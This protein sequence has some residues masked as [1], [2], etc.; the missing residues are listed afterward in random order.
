M[1]ATRLLT[2]ADADALADL[3]R[4][5]RDFLAPWEPV[6]NDDLYTVDG[7]RAVIEGALAKHEQGTVLPHVIL[8]R[9]HGWPHHAQ[10]H[11]AGRVPVM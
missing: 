8:D 5:N 4:V 11:R 3:Y 9:C 2:L 6:R 1:S 10:Q 7:Q